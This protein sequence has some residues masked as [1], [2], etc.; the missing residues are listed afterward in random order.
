[1]SRAADA[2]AQVAAAL[3]RWGALHVLHNNAYWALPGHTLL[4]VGEDEWDRTQAITLKSMYLM[5]RAAI[6][7][8]LQNGGGSIDNTASVA[9]IVGSRNFSAYASA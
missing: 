1:M 7:A 2:E 8:L 6:P 3:Q 5:S 4:D 9:G